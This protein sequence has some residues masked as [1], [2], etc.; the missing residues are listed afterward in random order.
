[1]TVF[2]SLRKLPVVLSLV[3]LLV[4]GSFVV[5]RRTAFRAT[6]KQ[7]AAS[8]GLAVVAAETQQIASANYGRLPLSFEANQGQAAAP[9]KFLSRGSNYN[10]LLSET[11]AALQLHTRATEQAASIKLKLVGANTQPQLGGL[12]PL[13]GKVNYLLG[14]NPQQWR[15]NVPTYAKVRYA[16]VY[17]GVDLVYYG[18]QEKLE[19][20]FVVAPG[21]DP[22]AIRLRFEGVEQLRL[23]SNGDL[24]LQTAEGEVR[25]QRP[26]V[27][28][29]GDSGQQSVAGEYVI[30]SQREVSF[31]IGAYDTRR[32]LVVDPVLVYSTSGITGTKIIVD[33][34]G[35][36]YVSSSFQTG[37]IFVTKLNAE[38][39][40]T[41][42]STVFGGNGADMGKLGAVD[43]Q[44]NAY[45]IGSS[46]SSNLPNAINRLNG[47]NF[48]KTG[49]GGNSWNRDSIGLPS[50]KVTDL[51]VDPKHPNIIYAVSSGGPIRKSVDGG[52]NWLSVSSSL[53]PDSY[54]IE[55]LS[56]FIDPVNPET[57]YYVDF[58]NRLFKTENGGNSWQ[59]IMSE[60][61]VDNFALA[62]SEPKTL[63]FTTAFG[64]VFRS[65]NGG[66]S[67]QRVAG[68]VGPSGYVVSLAVDS[69]N[70]RTVYAGTDQGAYKSLDGGSSWNEVSN[71]LPR[72]ET[73]TWVFSLTVDPVNSATLY[74]YP[75]S[76][77][78]KSTNGG[79]NW[80][81]LENGLESNI[82]RPSLIIDPRNPATLYL[83]PSTSFSGSGVYKSTDGGS[84][85][86]SLSSDRA[87]N[88]VMALAIDPLNSSNL[89]LGTIGALPDA[90]VAK[91]SSTGTEVIYSSYLGGSVG[92]AAVDMAVDA[93]GNIYLTG[94]TDSNN[95]P[96]TAEALQATP[97]GNI[98]ND[99]FVAKLDATGKLIYSTYL[100]GRG[101]EEAASLALTPTGSLYVAGTTHSPDFPLKNAWQTTVGDNYTNSFVTKLDLTKRGTEALIFSTYLVPGYGNIRKI[102]NVGRVY[103]L[104]GS[105]PTTPDAFQKT[106]GV[107]ILAKFDVEART[108]VYATKIGSN[109]VGG[110]YL[111]TLEYFSD[112]AVDAAGSVYLTGKTSSADFPVTPTAFQP[113][114]GGGICNYI[115]GSTYPCTD[116]FVMKVNPTGSALVY[117][118][119]FG[120]AENDEGLAIA[121]D[122][123]GNAYFA[124]FGFIAKV[125]AD[126]RSTAISS[127]SAASF[128]PTLALESI[129]AAFGTG[130]AAT[131]QTAAAQLPD[132]LDGSALLV[133]DSNG[134]E[135]TAPLF[136]ISPNQINFQVPSGLSPGASTLAV[137]H[138]GAVIA[139][140]ATQLV[141]V[142]P[143]L[144]AANA[145]GRGVAAAVALRVKA[146]GVQSYE[147]VARY[148][149]QSRQF[150]AVPLD[151]GGVD[152]QVFLILFGTGVRFRSALTAVTTKIGGVDVPVSF[153]GAQGQLVGLDQINVQLLRSLAGRGEMDVVV[154]VDGKTANAVR[155]N[156]K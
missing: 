49:D 115:K 44:G 77:I 91:L 132:E 51:V 42:Y 154:T 19:Y 146:N 150:V 31:A 83:I 130:L 11:E 127:V 137:T 156:I 18:N 135:R 138:K 21:A 140:G 87:L 54:V 111:L 9:V 59:Q 27:Y 155:V 89:Y 93:V 53:P 71:G 33:N 3:L 121:V 36:A 67:W 148:D 141:T 25:Q 30:K 8:R 106:P 63:Y 76:S 92:D 153:A 74:C 38:G 122:A 152:E 124:G 17:P 48:F 133:T 120:R 134:A 95:F 22:H 35:N 56:L 110:P 14:N 16:Q 149:E 107:L 105:L 70:P 100:G 7:T 61:S 2:R 45:L 1:M 46:S 28:Q 145:N 143:G 109:N 131:T 119:F 58:K 72:G 123:A 15:T 142:A 40:A 13:S 29:E 20:D 103:L 32:P 117:S 6:S 79:M 101:A 81:R 41:V 112:L 26:I 147:P 90:F 139:S 4:V 84:N 125:S 62:P 23:D 24:L 102:D 116:A 96:I 118:S 55:Q 80:F 97:G 85:W 57:L 94:N 75:G 114:I 104:G 98:W 88:N 144:F 52:N 69:K 47:G 60:R 128:A 34:A 10:L 99:T 39:T 65:D 37:N 129:A 43:A 108:L 5:S 136:F 12:E 64:E 78:Y 82:Y 126:N 113:K 151:L 86:V 50:E 68:G 73:S 66:A